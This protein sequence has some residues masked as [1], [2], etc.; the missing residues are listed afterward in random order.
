MISIRNKWCLITGASR[1]IGLLTAKFMA[2]K[3]CNLVLHSRNIKNT[4][5][6][7]GYVKY[8]GVD[9]Y[10]VQAELSDQMDVVKMLDEIEKRGTDID[11]IF[12]N[13]AIQLTYQ[14]AYWDTNIDDF[15][16]SMQINLI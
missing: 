12:N 3:G 5:D 15:A 10:S 9:A 2:E 14:E 8:L 1:G 11:I 4:E 13:A 16:L 7:L 6:L